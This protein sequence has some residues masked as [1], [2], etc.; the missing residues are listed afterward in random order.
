MIDIVDE[1]VDRLSE[2]NLSD[3]SSI[4]ELKKIPV[5][6]QE[7]VELFDQSETEEAKVESEEKFEDHHDVQD[8]ID[9]KEQIDGNF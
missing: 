9:V 4:G 7:Q 3:Q 5:F 1:I 8:V 2:Y 6:Y